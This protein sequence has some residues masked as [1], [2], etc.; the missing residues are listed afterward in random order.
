MEMGFLLHVTD[1]TW[2]AAF[3]LPR[4]IKKLNQE[5]PVELFNLWTA[6]SLQLYKKYTILFLDEGKTPALD[7]V[8][9]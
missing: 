2:K 7:K 6:G 5:M 4:G 9:L 8:G 3:L 1:Y